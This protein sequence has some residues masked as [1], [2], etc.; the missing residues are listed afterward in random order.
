[1]CA[2]ELLTLGQNCDLRLQSFQSVEKKQSRIL[3]DVP[4]PGAKSTHQPPGV[5][6]IPNLDGNYSESSDSGAESDSENFSVC[7]NRDKDRVNKLQM[8]G[9]KSTVEGS[10][11]PA[12]SKPCHI[13]QENLKRKKVNKNDSL[14]KVSNREVNVKE[15]SQNSLNN[16]SDSNRIAAKHRHFKV[17]TEKT[18]NEHNSVLSE[19]INNFKSIQS[20]IN[21]CDSINKNGGEGKTMNL[22]TNVTTLAMSVNQSSSLGSVVAFPSSIGTTTVCMSSLNA[23]GGQI[24]A[25]AGVNLPHPPVLVFSGGNAYPAQINSAGGSSSNIILGNFAGAVP[26]ALIP[27]AG[28]NKALIQATAV[29]V[30]G[31]EILKVPVGTPSGPSGGLVTM[32]QSQHA[33]VTVSSQPASSIVTSTIQSTLSPKSVAEERLSQR[34]NR[35]E[36]SIQDDGTVHW[37]CNVCAKVC[38]SESDLKI[39]KKRHKI[40]EALICPYCK[41]SYVDQHRYAVHVRIH[42]GETPFH[43]DLCGKG[44]RDDRKMKLHMARHN[45]GLSHKCHLCPRS[46]EGPKALEKHLNAHKTGRYVAPKVI[47]KSDGTTA[48][49]LPED[50]QKDSDSPIPSLSG[51]RPIELER[52]SLVQ[53]PVIV[54]P[55][56]ISKLPEG[57]S[58]DLK[59]E[60]SMEDD[61]RS[62]C[63]SMISLS[64]DDIY[65]YNVNQTGIEN[66]N[67]G[68]ALSF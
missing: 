38:P 20:N 8:S 68:T 57:I 60:G 67:E 37:S 50:K 53:S 3:L 39:H 52:P 59:S 17:M 51:E 41:R 48:M 18:S 9:S 55:P 65:Q 25:V 30:Q 47:Q 15:T 6:T 10:C 46:F 21:V 62:A 32:P 33:A 5:G 42:T 58:F 35:I 54:D 7:M 40:D 23:A 56:H 31:S 22:N 24:V 13:L 29:S 34:E 27:G 14:V 11:P 16:F 2:H 61:S 1:M 28:S 43:C 12:V 64:M 66:P 63:S 26:M 36:P 49:A 44:F 4:N 19:G 45:S